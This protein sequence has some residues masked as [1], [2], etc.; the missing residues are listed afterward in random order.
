ME[1]YE[2]PF[3]IEVVGAE[4]FENGDL[5]MW[6]TTPNRIWI[7]T[8]DRDEGQWGWLLQDIDYGPMWSGSAAEL[9]RA[10][11][12]AMHELFLLEP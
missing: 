8:F 4:E 12:E 9:W 1:Y 6:G 7:A 11:A 2:L 10:V 5:E 3:D